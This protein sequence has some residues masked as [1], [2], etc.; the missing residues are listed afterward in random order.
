M[1]SVG[2]NFEEQAAQWLVDQGCKLVARN[3][4]AKPGEIDII[5]LDQGCLV[6]LEVRVRRH[7]GYASA[8]ASVDWRKQR[9]IAGAAQVFLQRH[10]QLTDLPCRF[11]VIAFQPPQSGAGLALHWIRAA[12]TA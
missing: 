10:P 12:F 6:F 7:T 1:K 5:A 8:A 11:D 4:R 3:F 9:R 2:D